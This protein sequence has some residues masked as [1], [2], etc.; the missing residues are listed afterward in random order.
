MRSTSS[1]HDVAMDAILNF[2]EDFELTLA[3]AALGINHGIAA[4]EGPNPAASTRLSKMAD[5]IKTLGRKAT[6]TGTFD[7]DLNWIPP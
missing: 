5:S 2:G 4:F 7:G 3:W 6:R 1:I